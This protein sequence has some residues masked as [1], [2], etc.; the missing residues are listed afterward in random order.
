METNMSTTSESAQPT[1][2]ANLKRK[3][4][5]TGKVLKTTLAG[6]VVDIG[7]ETPGVVHI[8]QLQEKPTNRVEDVVQVGQTVEV[9]V[10]RVDAKKGRL[11]L[12][13]IEPL[14]M[15]WRDIN[16]GMAIKGKVTRLER[17]GAFVDV[18]AERPGLVHISE[19][20]HD[21]IKTPGEVVKEGDE[22]E[23]Q[24]LEVNRRKKQ[25]KLSMKALEEKPDVIVKALQQP[26]VKEK[27]KVE[28]ETVQEEVIPT[29]MEMAL[30]E[31]VERSKSQE[32]APKAKKKQRSSA[33][34]QEIERILSRTL[35]NKVRT[36]K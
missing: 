22:V 31:A 21:Y 26:K 12:T 14:A 25:I 23:V 11:E 1:D 6:A 24:V 15:E 30:R 32:E 27:A 18:G 16:V 7:L 35:E 17:F 34:D 13:M 36:G 9:W 29:A 8:S 20:T 28:E 10:R 3:T 4:K 33:V 2:I 19:M 5:F